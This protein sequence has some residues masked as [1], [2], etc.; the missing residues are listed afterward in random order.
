[1]SVTEGR[2]KGRVREKEQKSKEE[3]KL[4]QVRKRDGEIKC[5][6]EGGHKRC[7]ATRKREHS[8]K[9]LHKK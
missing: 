3:Q 5:N 9:G 8:R 2:K 6:K 4:Y 7:K 1:M